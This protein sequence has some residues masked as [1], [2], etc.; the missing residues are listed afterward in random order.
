VYA[1]AFAGESQVVGGC[2]NGKIRRWK[3]ED[4]QQQGPT[5][6]ADNSVY[7]AVVSQDGRWIVSG[8]GGNAILWNAATHEKVREFTEH[9]NTVMGVDISSDGSRLATADYNNVQMFSIPSGDR[10]L[11]PLPHP[12]VSDVKFSPDGT[13]FATASEIRG[14]SVSLWDRMSH[15]QISSLITHTKAVKCVALSPSGR[16]L[17]CGNGNNVT[18]YDLRDILSLEY[19]SHSVSVHSL[20]KLA[21]L[22]IIML[23][24]C[25]A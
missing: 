22:T 17:A 15:T 21:S 2:W 19:F 9:G 18:I 5:M 10:L 3:I 8:A 4:G 13:R 1:V 11:P 16:Y 20:M 7:S 24:S 23:F 12:N 25:P 6:K 14:S